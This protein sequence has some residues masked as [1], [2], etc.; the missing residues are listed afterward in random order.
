MHVHALIV[1][2]TYVPVGDARKI[3]SHLGMWAHRHLC[4]GPGMNMST[5]PYN[6]PP[7]GMLPSVPL[8]AS[9]RIA[10]KRDL[11][12]WLSRF[13]ENTDTIYSNKE[14]ILRYRES[15]LIQPL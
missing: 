4:L 8:P 1:D 9:N 15:R 6:Q 14:D 5:C 10:N 11:F 3:C 12:L 13:S 2:D 7:N